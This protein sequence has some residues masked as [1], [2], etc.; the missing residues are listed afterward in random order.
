MHEYSYIENDMAILM[1]V[2]CI[3]YVASDI[4]IFLPPRLGALFFI[5]MNQVFGNLSAVDLF[6]KEKA[7]FMYARDT[8][9]CFHN[10]Y[11]FTTAFTVLSPLVATRM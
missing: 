6:I 10:A 8:L 7:L 1:H 11:C 4:K 3:G 9:N 2:S 5:I